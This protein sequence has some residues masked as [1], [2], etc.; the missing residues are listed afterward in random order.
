MQRRA[1]IT[2]LK[3]LSF[4]VEKPK[5]FPTSIFFGVEMMENFVEVYHISRCLKVDKFTI[6][7]LLNSLHLVIIIIV[8][9]RV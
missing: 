2:A 1:K 6:Y 8:N 9:P 7:P 3:P 5:G 4:D